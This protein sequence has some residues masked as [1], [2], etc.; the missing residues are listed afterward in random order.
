MADDYVPV[1]RVE[2]D[3]DVQAER[4]SRY[5]EQPDEQLADDEI[6]DREE[7]FLRGYDDYGESAWI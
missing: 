3:D 6:T 7:G 1:E 4:V 5:E 2:I